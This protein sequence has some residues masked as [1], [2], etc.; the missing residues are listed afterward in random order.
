MQQWRAILL[1]QLTLLES[2]EA[3]DNVLHILE[4]LRTSRATQVEFEAVVVAKART[5]GHSWGDIGEAMGMSRQHVW[6][7]YSGVEGHADQ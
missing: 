4:T 6:R 5:L 2:W 1:R 3:D 7:K